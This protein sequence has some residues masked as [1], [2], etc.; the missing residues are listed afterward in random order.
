MYDFCSS[1]EKKKK[2]RQRNACK[3]TDLIVWTP[4]RFQQYM[5]Q[6]KQKQ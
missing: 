4:K 3:Q 1:A 6:K 2:E 5:N